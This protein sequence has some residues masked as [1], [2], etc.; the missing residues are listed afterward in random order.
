MLRTDGV[1]LGKYDI[2]IIINNNNNNKINRRLTGGTRV[3]S[4]WQWP[5]D[6]TD[7]KCCWDYL[8]YA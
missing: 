4:A 5:S 2:I 6:A 8:Y 7:K 3:T 1:L